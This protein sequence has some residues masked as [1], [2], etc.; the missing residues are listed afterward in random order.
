MI[1]SCLVGVWE[2]NLGPLKGHQVFL[3]TELSPQALE[4]LLF[5]PG[6]PG[7]HYGVEDDLELLI[8]LPPHPEGWDYK[9]VLSLFGFYVL[10]CGA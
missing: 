4:T 2:L 10:F 8:P 9:C 6:W 3:T 1:V 5:S 7:T